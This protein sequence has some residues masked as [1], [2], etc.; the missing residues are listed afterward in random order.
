M[1]HTPGPALPSCPPNAPS[2]L[3]PAFP[4]AALLV[5]SPD[6]PGSKLI[7]KLKREGPV[8]GNTEEMPPTQTFF[9]TG[10]P[11][12]WT[13]QRRDGPPGPGVRTVLLAKAGEDLGA[14]KPREPEAVPSVRAPPPNDTSFACTSKGVYEN[15]RRWQR[16]KSLARRHFPATPDAEALACFFIPVLRSLA[17]LR[18]DMTLEEGIPR[19]VQEWE[20]SSNFE[21]MIF[22]EM[23]EK[24]M[25]FE[26]EEEQQIQKMKLLASCSQFQALAPKPT[27]PTLSPASESGPQQVYIPKKSACKS[28]QPRRRQRR[29]PSAS[30]PGAP[31]EIPAE[32]VH[33]YAEIMEGLETTW[34]EE[35]EEEGGEKKEHGPC[36]DPQGQEDGIFPDPS[37]LQYMDSLCDDEEFVCKVEAVLHPQ[38]MARL[39]SPE[40]SQNPLDLVDELEQELHLTPS[41]LTEKRLLALSEEEKDPLAYPTSRSGSMPSQSEEEDEAG[42]DGKGEGPSGQTTKR[43]S[44]SKGFRAAGLAPP[45]SRSPQEPHLSPQWGERNFPSK[46]VRSSSRPSPH[47]CYGGKAK[48]A[49]LLPS[50]KSTDEEE[51]Q[52]SRAGGPLVGI[53]PHGQCI[54]MNATPNVSRSSN[55]T[56]NV[57]SPGRSEVGQGIPRPSA[58]ERSKQNGS[59]GR[60]AKGQEEIPKAL[61]HGSH[62]LVG[63]FFNRAQPIRNNLHS[64]HNKCRK[65]GGIREVQGLKKALTVGKDALKGKDESQDVNKILAVGQIVGEG[66]QRLILKGRGELSVDQA[67][68]SNGQSQ[69]QDNKGSKDNANKAELSCQGRETVSHWDSRSQQGNQELTQLGGERDSHRETVHDQYKFQP[70]QK[71]SKCQFTVVAT[72]TGNVN[73]H[74]Q[75]LPGP[76][77][78]TSSQ[79]PKAES[80]KQPQ[81]EWKPTKT[82]TAKDNGPMKTTKSTGGQRPLQKQLTSARPGGQPSAAPT[83]L[84]NDGPPVEPSGGSG[85][86]LT[87]SASSGIGVLKCKQPGR[88]SET[89][90]DATFTVLESPCS[91]IQTGLQTPQKSQQLLREH[92]AAP[93]CVEDLS[94]QRRTLTPTPIPPSFVLMVTTANGDS[95]G[96]SRAL[97]PGPT[98]PN[99]IPTSV[100]PVSQRVSHHQSHAS[101][102]PKLS[103]VH[104]SKSQNSASDITVLSKA[105]GRSQKA[106]GASMRLPA[107]PDAIREGAFK[108]R[109]NGEEEEDEE[110][111][112]FSL[113]ASKLSLS[114]HH[115][116]GHLPVDPGGAR[117][118]LPT[119]SWQEGAKTRPPTRGEVATQEGT[120]LRN[121]TPDPKPPTQRCGHKRRN[122]GSTTQRTKRLRNQ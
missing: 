38:F 67:D 30:S 65:Q 85:Q 22:Y 103:H 90:P 56:R 96:P 105:E 29:P 36:Q 101:D 107:P 12:S 89:L 35:E 76:G 121:K 19:A 73:P 24:F 48:E 106:T 55:S 61:E 50:I 77:N 117:P 27:K 32:A 58:V 9:L 43:P 75:I 69:M 93:P 33:Q 64:A 16:Y 44:F 74:G 40:T 45:V 60:K 83:Q 42:G 122:A 84:E 59:Q 88:E 13:A 113:L 68:Q 5:T 10:M 62:A 57:T 47:Q 97:T 115:D 21:R 92:C 71:E 1:A 63:R 118:S 51:T 116:H 28:R 110:L 87:S 91:S 114:P 108:H 49:H 11:L 26:A 100:P 81:V 99:A 39:L 14:R 52:K 72:Q 6:A 3:L 80:Q 78:K 66:V 53:S 82:I 4:G 119:D 17:R 20:H 70:T 23:A 2:L 34:K 54:Q 37:L 15:Y 112:S 95:C 109:T 8:V 111:S 94:D 31:R 120:A 98:S 86:E 18:P 41:Q 46:T 104:S 7:I 25:E 79:T 102:E